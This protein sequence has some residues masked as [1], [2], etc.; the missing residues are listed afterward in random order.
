MKAQDLAPRELGSHTR[1]RS[2]EGAGSTL[3]VE[4]PSGALQGM[5]GGGDGSRGEDLGGRGRG[6]RNRAAGLGR[7]EWV[8][9][10]VTGM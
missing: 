4:R 3:S 5:A 7:S 9:V 2:R 1:A 8:D 6:R 10:Y